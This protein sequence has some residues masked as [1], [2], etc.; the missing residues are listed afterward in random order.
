[1]E[2][3]KQFT[4]GH[5][6]TDNELNTVLFSTSLGTLRESSGD[7]IKLRALFDSGLQASFITED[8]AM[9]LM[10]PTQRS[11]FLPWVLPIFRRP[12]LIASEVE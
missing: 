8:V 10:V 9:A 2:S 5:F 12:M 3:T 7:A 6:S 4:T 11:Q 1:M